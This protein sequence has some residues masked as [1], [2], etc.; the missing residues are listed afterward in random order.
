MTLFDTHAHYDDPAFDPDR[1]EV[2]SDLKNHGVALALCPGCDL[3]SSRKAV[4]LA[5]RYDFLYAAVGV[6]PEEAKLS[7]P[8]GSPRWRSSPAAPR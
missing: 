2:L 5:E 3:A 1:D 8:T 7:P 6:H 4:E